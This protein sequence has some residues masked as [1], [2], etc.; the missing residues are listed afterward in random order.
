MPSQCCVTNVNCEFKF[1]PHKNSLRDDLVSLALSLTISSS[2]LNCFFLPSITWPVIHPSHFLQ[3][4]VRWH[5]L[6]ALSL[7]LT[8]QLSKKVT[9]EATPSRRWL[10]ASFYAI[11]RPFLSDFLQLLAYFA[12]LIWRNSMFLCSTNSLERLAITAKSLLTAKGNF[13]NLLI[14][15]KKK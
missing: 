5:R 1:L 2:P 7:Q 12:F 9:S 4:N 3:S 14:K 13:N 11:C 10:A 15:S 6:E 8:V